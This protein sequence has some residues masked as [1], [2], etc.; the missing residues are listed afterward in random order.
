MPEKPIM[1][2]RPFLISESSMRARPG[3][4]PRPSG[5]KPKSPGARPEPWSIWMVAAVEMAST[6]PIQKSIWPMEPAL[7]A[8]SWRAVILVDAL[9]TVAAPGNWKMSWA[10]QP[11]AASMATRQCLISA[12]RNHL[13]SNQAEM[14]SGSKP[15]SPGTEPSNMSVSGRPRGG[16]AVG[17]CIFMALTAPARRGAVGRTP[18]GAKAEADATIAAQRD[19]RNI[20]AGGG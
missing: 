8:A 11:A 19:S 18:E 14:V 20:A 7:T 15:A 3:P 2:R 1:A 16:M 13:L 10:M 4:L 9:Y 12:S 17:S 5:S 6:K